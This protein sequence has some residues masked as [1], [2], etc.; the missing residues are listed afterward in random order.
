MVWH[1]TNLSVQKIKLLSITCG[2]TKQQCCGSGSGIQCLF[3]PWIRLFRIPD[4]GSQTYIF[5][6]AFDNFWSK[7]FYNCLKIAPSFFLQH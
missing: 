4:L 5:F 3:D 7:K 6:R 1:D 2:I